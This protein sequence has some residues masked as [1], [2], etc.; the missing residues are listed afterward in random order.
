LA[1]RIQG[2]VQGLSQS[3]TDDRC[4]YPLVAGV[5]LIV[6]VIFGVLFLSKMTA[7]NTKRR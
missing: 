3:N 1:L 7:R 6:A 2:L 5:L 4:A